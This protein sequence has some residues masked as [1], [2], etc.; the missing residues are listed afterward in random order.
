[1]NCT[2]AITLTY[3]LKEKQRKL[4]MRPK[5]TDYIT[6]TKAA[7]KVYELS[8]VTRKRGTVYKWAEIGR[9]SAEH[10]KV[11]KLRVT[12]RLGRMYT[13]V[14]WLKKFIKEIS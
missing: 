13:T 1:M 4:Q 8:G 10:G 2:K 9:I 6:L 12:N 7:E 5:I 11:V 3:T 14:D